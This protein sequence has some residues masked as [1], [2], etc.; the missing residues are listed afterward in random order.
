MRIRTILLLTAFVASPAAAA[1]QLPGTSG[2]SCGA[3]GTGPEI[4]VSIEGFKDR[5]GL[6]RVELYPANDVDFLADD[7]VLIAAHKPF[8]RIEQRVPSSGPVA[9]CIRASSAGPVALVVLHDRNA[10]RRFAVLVDGVGFGGNPRLR[11]A[12]PRAADAEIV[13]PSQGTRV[14]IDLN[15]WRGLGMRPAQVSEK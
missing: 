1:E 11:W 12:R 7:A 6:V 14:R 4:S 8:R 15:Y 10:D 13:V 3:G 2:A 9:V 5:R